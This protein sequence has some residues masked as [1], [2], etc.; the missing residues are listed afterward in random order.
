M[1]NFYYFVTGLK[2]LPIIDE[3][4]NFD[5]S[6]KDFIKNIS[7]E[8][9]LKHRKPIQDYLL[10]YDNENLV[11]ILDGAT[12]LETNLGIYT[13]DELIEYIKLYK[14]GAEYSIEFL[15]PKYWSTFI[16]GYISDK[17][18]FKNILPIDELTLYYFKYLQTSNNSFLKDYS[19]YDFNLRN[20]AASINSKKFN[21]DKENSVIKIN[22]FAERLIKESSFDTVVKEEFGILSDELNFI[23]KL[24]F[25]EME[26]KL[27]LKRIERID[28]LL[29]YEYFSI[30]KLL[31][32]LIKLSIV[33]RWSSIDAVKG[34]EVFKTITD[35]LRKNISEKNDKK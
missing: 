23:E 33:E 32:Y 26:L 4:I 30:D 18:E 1:R 14:E 34:K 13:Y 3:N 10:R 17:R 22:E 8:V 20:L 6:V 11:K 25:L 21:I 15:T 27:D 31:G 7:E 5:Y 19:D 9:P 35:K 16:S 29:V 12:K 2:E 28:E 24:G